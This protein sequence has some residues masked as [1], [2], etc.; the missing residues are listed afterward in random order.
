MKFS[1]FYEE[2]LEEAQGKPYNADKL[3]AA[4]NQ[5][6]DIFKDFFL[7][8]PGKILNF[9]FLDYFKKSVQELQG[10]DYD[11]NDTESLVLGLV[12]NVADMLDGKPGIYSGL[13]ASKQ[14]E[15]FRELMNKFPEVKTV[16]GPTLGIK[17]TKWVEGGRGRRPKSATQQQSNL[18]PEFQGR[19][20]SPLF[21]SEPTKD[22]EDD[23]IGSTESPTP[24]KKRGRP[25]K[26]IDVDVTNVP[27]TP[28]VQKRRG[29]P[30]LGGPQAFKRFE[31]KLYKVHNN[32]ESQLSKMKELIQQMGSRADYFGKQ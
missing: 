14:T 24:A 27:E 10:S 2:V 16:L 8:S 22:V 7:N 23:F 15:F 3:D 25:R 5:I 26:N 32:L 1:F 29:R 6:D 19:K 21:P 17:E 13:N 30:M 31:D 20:L 11:V 28:D 4:V 12:D 18:P 9:P